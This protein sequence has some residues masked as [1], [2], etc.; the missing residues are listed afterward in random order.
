MWVPC[1]FPL[2][3]MPSR[4]T[5]SNWGSPR[6]SCEASPKGESFN[7]NVL[8][9]PK[10]E[11]SFLMGG[12]D[13]HEAPGGLAWWIDRSVDQWWMNRTPFKVAMAGWISPQLPGSQDAFGTHRA[14]NPSA[15]GLVRC[16]Q[17]D[18]KLFNKH[19][20]ENHRKPCMFQGI[21]PL[22]WLTP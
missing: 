1:Q 22:D 4:V 7:R 10:L 14:R 12:H 8:M 21:W 17:K 13:G 2:E 3:S 16:G 5:I 6:L 19:Q 20:N 15:K 9:G 18:K 11:K